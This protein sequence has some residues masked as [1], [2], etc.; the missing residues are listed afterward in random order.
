MKV[1]LKSKVELG[2]KEF[3]AGHQ[4]IPDHLFGNQAFKK[5]VKLGTI[6][7]HPRNAAAQAAQA[8]KDAHAHGKS[9]LLKE[10]AAKAVEA[11]SHLKNNK[12]VGGKSLADKKEEAQ[13]ELR[14]KRVQ[15]A[16]PAPFVPPVVAV[17]IPAEASGDA[18][19]VPAAQAAPAP[20]SAPIQG[21]GKKDKS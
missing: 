6:V 18:E 17:P 15:P 21:T 14:T 12:S 5:H 9:P 16:E 19:A 4:E 8:S 11:R 13:A 7:V 2:N 3:A 1:T 20:S 10:T